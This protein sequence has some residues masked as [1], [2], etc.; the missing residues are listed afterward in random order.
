MLPRAKGKTCL[1][2]ATYAH[3]CNQDHSFAASSFAA[4]ITDHDYHHCFHPAVITNHVADCWP[5]IWAKDWVKVMPALI[6]CCVNIRDQVGTQQ[7]LWRKHKVHSACRWIFPMT[8]SEPEITWL[9]VHCRLWASD[10]W[11]T[12]SYQYRN[13]PSNC[14]R[15][16]KPQSCQCSLWSPAAWHTNIWSRVKCCQDSPFA[17]AECGVA[18]HCPTSAHRYTLQIHCTDTTPLHT[19]GRLTILEARNDYHKSRETHHFC[20]WSHC[21]PVCATLHLENHSRQ[22]AWFEWQQVYTLCK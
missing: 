3:V 19:L 21:L 7:T 10:L 22:V 12:N 5:I 1:L 14:S 17:A 13:C 18:A 11:Y 16:Q 15:R 8:L 9:P 20:K 6:M 4:P 2:C